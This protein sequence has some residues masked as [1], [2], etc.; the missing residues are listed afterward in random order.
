MNKKK[1]DIPASDHSA[2]HHDNNDDW[3]ERLITNPISISV[4]I[5]LVM[6]CFVVI[7]SRDYYG[8]G[9]F[10]ENLLAEAHGVLIDILMLGV[11]I[12]WFQQK[13]NNKLLARRYQD[14]IDDFRNWKAEEAARRI[15]GNIKRMNEIGITSIDLSNCYLRNMDMRSYR[16]DFSNLWRSDLSFCD[17]R[18]ASMVN[19][20]M[21]DINL[22]SSVLSSSV[23]KNAV[24]LKADLR[25]ADMRHSIFSGASMQ[26]S[27]LNESDLENA[28]FENADLSKADLSECN[29]T[30]ANLRNCVLEESVFEG[31][32][33]RKADLRGARGLT[34]MQLSKAHTL[35]ETEVD[36]DI[37]LELMECS[38]SL[39]VN[40]EVNAEW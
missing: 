36:E 25:N 5:F 34:A 33:I 3:F 8:P 30:G 13:G 27:K 31:T 37:L 1:Y 15:R 35:F 32:Y 39:F 24:L 29:L 4:A 21:E 40:P 2:N 16:L 14:E 18:N 20:Y 11:I 26:E 7:I 22:Y 12:V 17:I 38:A 6:L 23:F 19:A 28:S 10:T 9:S